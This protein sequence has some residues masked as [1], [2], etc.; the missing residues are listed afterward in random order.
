MRRPTSSTFRLGRNQTVASIP[1]S[2]S[3]YKY[4]V[5]I[6]IC[7]GLYLLQRCP[8]SSGPEETHQ[9]RNATE[10]NNSLKTM[11]VECDLLTC[12]SFSSVEIRERW[13]P[14]KR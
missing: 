10:G 8:R 7:T 11:Y 1:Q 12:C 14:A 9:D 4:T 3:L 2:L 5:R 6:L 13:V